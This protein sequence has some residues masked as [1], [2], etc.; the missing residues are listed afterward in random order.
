MSN[1][2][3]FLLQALFIVVL[4]PLL[5]HYLRLKSTV[6][7]VVV[8]ILLGITLGPTLLGRFAPDFYAYFFNPAALA[9][10]GS[11]SSIAV[12]FFAFA[13]GMHVDFK[14]LEGKGSAL[15]MISA[16]SMLLPTVLGLLAG[17]NW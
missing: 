6:P 1:I 11:I 17:L 3:I 9:T 4:P 7:L 10:L 12:L 8:Q 2:V 13:T 14:S 15:G 16:A 5:T